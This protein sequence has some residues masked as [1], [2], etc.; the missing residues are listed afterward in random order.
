VVHTTTSTRHVFNTI[1]WLV[2]IQ[3]QRHADIQTDRHVE[4]NTS[5]SLSRLE[6][7]L[8][9]QTSLTSVFI[10]ISDWVW[11]RRSA[12]KKCLSGYPKLIY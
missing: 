12:S 9:L 6:N 7:N 4:N 1:V 3:K 2:N 8:H 10:E 11:E 5:I